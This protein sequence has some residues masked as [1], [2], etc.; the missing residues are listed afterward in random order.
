MMLSTLPTE[1]AVK[2]AAGSVLT[3]GC[4]GRRFLAFGIGQP[5]TPHFY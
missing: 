1:S 5:A 4:V 3:I 2:R